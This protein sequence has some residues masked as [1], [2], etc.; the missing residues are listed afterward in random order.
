MELQ[1]SVRMLRRIPM[2]EPVDACDELLDVAGSVPV[3]V[4]VLVFLRVGVFLCAW[5]RGRFAQFETAVDAVIGAQRGGEEQASLE[6][7]PSAGL[8]VVMQ[9]VGCVCEQ[10]GSQVL[11]YV[12]CRQFSQVLGDLLLRVAP[13]EVGV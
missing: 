7:R 3:A 6:C 11:P 12:S 5:N 13:R 9:D 4:A 2:A 10:V 1:R 8:K